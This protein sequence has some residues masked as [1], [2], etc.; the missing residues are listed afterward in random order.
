VIV[1]VETPG[2]RTVGFLKMALQN[3]VVGEEINLDGWGI[4]RLGLNR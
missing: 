2:L 3:N 1:V 4:N